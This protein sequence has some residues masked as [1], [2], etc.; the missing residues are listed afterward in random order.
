MTV[1]PVTDDVS[2]SSSPPPIAVAVQP[3]LVSSSRSLEFRDKF[4]AGA[5]DQKARCKLGGK[6]EC[7]GRKE[8]YQ[9]EG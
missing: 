4:L 9:C 5:P 6:R 1:L 3:D 7:V 8:L 2:S